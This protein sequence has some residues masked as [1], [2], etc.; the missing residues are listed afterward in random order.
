I[1][2]WLASPLPRFAV[3][4]SWPANV[5]PLGNAAA[6][7]EPIGGE[8]L[9]LAMRSA[10]LAAGSVLD[11]LPRERLQR[12]FRRLW[13]VRGITCRA[14]ALTLSSPTLGS[15]LVRILQVHANL[16]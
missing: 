5:I 7:I 11:D 6:A 10:E 12:E 16:A 15:L 9:G 1:G 13:R 3:S 8:G 4:R 14:A 2:A